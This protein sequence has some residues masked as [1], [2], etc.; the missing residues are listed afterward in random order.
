MYG[1]QKVGLWHD[2]SDVA[3]KPPDSHEHYRHRRRNEGGRLPDCRRVPAH[4]L[5]P[6]AL[7]RPT[8]SSPRSQV[9]TH[10]NQDNEQ[11][12]TDS[13][14]NEGQNVSSGGRFGGRWVR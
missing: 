6:S 7:V 2:H 14:E 8:E 9:V 10:T 1:R 13:Q 3:I 4:F 11:N 5:R 12:N